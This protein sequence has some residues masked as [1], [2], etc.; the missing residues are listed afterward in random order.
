VIATPKA[1]TFGD[2]VDMVE[3]CLEWIYDHARA[4]LALRKNQLPKVLPLER[5]T[6]QLYL[7]SKSELVTTVPSLNSIQRVYN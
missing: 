6:Q 2:D 7:H 4:D 1:F 5:M 3:A